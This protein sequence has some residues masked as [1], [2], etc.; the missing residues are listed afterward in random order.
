MPAVGNLH[1][2][3]R[4]GRGRPR[5]LGRAIT[6]DDRDMRLTAQ[7]RRDARGGAVGQ[8]V[9]WAS[10]LQVDD[11]GAVGTPFPEGPVVDTDDAW[12][13]RCGQRQAPYQAQHGI[14]ACRHREVGQETSTCLATKGETDPGLRP[15]EPAGA[16]GSRRQE[17]RQG[18][19]ESVTRAIG[20]MAIEAPDPKAEMD[21]LP[22]LGKSAGRRS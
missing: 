17:L 14:G 3:W 10:A 2:R 4:A 21:G 18:L 8:E 6:R 11:N 15:S 1:G 5:V 13:V 20:V 9:D 7:P 16:S 12:R 22:M 19:H